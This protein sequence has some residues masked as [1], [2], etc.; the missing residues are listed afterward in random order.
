M[1]TGLRGHCN[2][3]PLLHYCPPCQNE[4]DFALQTEMC[5]WNK[6]AATIHGE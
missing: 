3:V 4:R 5:V 2:S 1:Y 6:C